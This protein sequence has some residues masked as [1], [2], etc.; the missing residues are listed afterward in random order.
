M[1]HESF[2]NPATAAVMN[3]H[4]VNIKVDR[5]ERPDLDSIY[6]QA[7][8][9]MTGHGGW[10]MTVFLTPEG[11]PFYGGTYFPPVDRHGMPSFTKI[12]LS[13]SEA[14]RT[15]PESIE[16]NAASI[17][18]I[19]SAAEAEA[20]SPGE[21]TAPTLERVY[22]GLAQRYDVEY[23]GFG[24][25]PKFPPTM[26][27]DFLL[28]YAT[29]TGTDYALEMALQTF[30]KMA[31]GGIYDQVGGGF[32]RYAVDGYWLVPHF[33]KMLYDNALLIRFGAQLYQV[34]NNAEVRRVTEETVEWLAK[35]MTS[36]AGG[37]YSSY[38]ADSEGHE[39]K[40]YVW[41]ESEVDAL[42]GG[43]SKLVK[44]YYGVTADGNFE[45]KNIFFIPTPLE[46]AAA[47]AGLDIKQANDVIA[48]SKKVLYS[49]RAKRVWPGLDDKV[50]ASWNG[51]ALRGVVEAA[52]TFDR[53]DFRQLALANGTFLATEIVREGRVFRTH[54]DGSTRI[55]GFLEDH[56]AVALGFLALFEQTNDIKWIKLAREITDS[57]VQWFWEPTT[58]TFYDSASDAEQL[59]TRPRDITDNAMPSG[60]SLAVELLFRM[61]DYVGN[62]EYRER[63]KFA[64]ESLAPGMER[65]PTSFG[66][67]LGAA[68]YALTFACHGEYCDMPSPQ[69]LEVA[70]TL[71]T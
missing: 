8:Q 21:V 43:D 15:R 41:D 28:R 13:V 1:A 2:E 20:H 68:E 54:K 45:K 19:Y 58:Q 18:E 60:T 5:E 35:E 39:G 36:A 11:V 4:Y 61:A 69:A 30:I 66:H 67:L 44:M 16:K 34:T 37:W 32:A 70:R 47:R 46:V 62:D 24:G 31:R 25:A 51:L 42:L 49:A 59:I 12:L 7:V 40:F 14:F 27:L 6:M 33:E 22:R 10:P 55:A 23:G 57:I 48:R 63:A 53:D 71:T 9:A 17:L 38:D 29:R 64:L 56:A 65:Y 3:E 50:I 52:R 26:T